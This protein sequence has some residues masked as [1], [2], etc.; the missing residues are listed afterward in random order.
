VGHQQAGRSWHTVEAIPA[1]A[2]RNSNS[3]STQGC[4]MACAGAGACPAVVVDSCCE[5]CS[6][7]AHV[8]PAIYSGAAAAPP[9]HRSKGQVRAPGGG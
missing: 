2:G 5:G 4:P 8:L 6:R 1:P 9:E 7:P 3:S